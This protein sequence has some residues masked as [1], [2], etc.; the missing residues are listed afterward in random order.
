MAKG[1]STRERDGIS[2]EREFGL[3]RGKSVLDV[4]FPFARSPNDELAERR[5]AEP[6]HFPNQDV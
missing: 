3:E 2:V 5:A 6:S 4:A 1:D